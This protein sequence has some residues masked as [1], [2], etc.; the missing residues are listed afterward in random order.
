MK[1]LPAQPSSP[2]ATRP[3]LLTGLGQHVFGPAVNDPNGAVA[4]ATSS[5]F[6]SIVLYLGVPA[7]VLGGR[8]V[9][10]ALRETRYALAT[11]SGAP[12]RTTSA[13]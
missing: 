1:T 10:C 6:P 11:W 12:I 5:I 7:S 8:R 9:R 4:D 13:L 2:T 3:A